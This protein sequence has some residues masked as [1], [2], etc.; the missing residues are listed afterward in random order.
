MFGKNSPVLIPTLNNFGELFRDENDFEHGIPL[1][2][3]AQ[4]I[5]VKTLGKNHTYTW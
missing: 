2:E 4:Q 5:A 1:V 3:R